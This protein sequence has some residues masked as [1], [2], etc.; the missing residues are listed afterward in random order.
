MRFFADYSFAIY[1]IRDWKKERHSTVYDQLSAV[2]EWEQI[3]QLVSNEIN[4]Q[5]TNACCSQVIQ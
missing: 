1:G 3:V 4:D 5:D 2:D